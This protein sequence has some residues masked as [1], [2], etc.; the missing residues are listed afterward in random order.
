MRATR[1]W[2]CPCYIAHT[3][4]GYIECENCQYLKGDCLF[5]SKF[6]LMLLDQNHGLLHMAPSSYM[7]TFSLYISPISFWS[8]FIHCIHETF[9]HSWDSSPT[10][11]METFDLF[12]GMYPPCMTNPNLQFKN[13]RY[14]HLCAW[15]HM[16]AGL[17]LTCTRFGTTISTK[18][19][20]I[21]LHLDV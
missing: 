6:Q 21:T 17:L 4:L 9:N 11:D 19:V 1:G 12:Y 14:T 3:S 5:F 2:G 10:V 16:F 13:F 18:T 20:V 8:V 7:Y 15:M